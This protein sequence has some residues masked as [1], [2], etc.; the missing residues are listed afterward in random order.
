MGNSVQSYR[1]V[2]SR[3]DIPLFC[4]FSVLCKLMHRSVL[5]PH[6][7]EDRKSKNRE[8]GEKPHSLNP[9]KYLTFN[10]RDSKRG[11]EQRYHWIAIKVTDP[12]F[13]SSVSV[14]FKNLQ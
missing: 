7:V 10:Q 11:Q 13:Y 5:L 3:L 6:W 12:F 14:H 4:P 1:L 8:R 9:I 2:R